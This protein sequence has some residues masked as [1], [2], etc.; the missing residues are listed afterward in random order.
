[1]T[2]GQLQHNGLFKGCVGVFAKYCRRVIIDEAHIIANDLSKQSRF[3]RSFTVGYK[4]AITGTPFINNIYD[5]R[6]YARWFEFDNWKEICPVDFCQDYV[7]RRTKQDVDL[8]L[9]KLTIKIK[10]FDILNKQHYID[11]LNRLSNFCCEV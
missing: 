11:K 7:L 10:E 5:A 8:Q 4:W 9:P 3:L 6:K 1:M 2:H